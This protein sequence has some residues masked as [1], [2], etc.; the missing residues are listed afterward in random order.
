MTFCFVFG[1]EPWLL[2]PAVEM[3]E[4]LRSKGHNVKVIY[5]EYLGKKPAEKDFDNA[6]TF[7][8]IEKQQGYKRFFI[9]LL[10]ADTIKKICRNTNIDVLIACDIISLQSLASANIR[11][12][13]K[14][15]WGF[16]IVN[17]IVKFKLSLG[18]YRAFVFPNWINKL[19]FFLAPSQSRIEKILDRCKQDIPHRVIFNCRRLEQNIIPDRP[20]ANTE[21]KLVYAGRISDTQYITEIIDSIA[22]IDETIDI[23][24]QLAG[25]CDESYYSYLKNRI[26]NNPVLVH[27][28]S[29]VGRLSLE[30]VYV[31]IKSAD[32]GFVFYNEMMGVEAKD[33]APNKLSDYIAGGI[34]SIGGAQPSMKYWLEDRGAGISITDINKENIAYAIKTIIYDDKFKNK[35][36]LYELYEKELNMDIQSDK[37]IEVVS[38]LK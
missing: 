31:L 35:S 6:N 15:Y 2:P 26:D 38:N 29:L 18:I 23:R 27:R 17:K 16:E 9:H 1:L 14:G 20:I 36:V 8:I 4:V 34:W 37:L 30:D 10:L 21:Y 24:L 3:M 12:T 25:P 13:K 28:V 22:L 19:D 7:T 11:K 5:S 32:I 33:P